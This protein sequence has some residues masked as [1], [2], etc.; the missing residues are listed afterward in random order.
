MKFQ[1][2]SGNIAK[3]RVISPGNYEIYFM[4]LV[5]TVL[6]NEELQGGAKWIA[7]AQWDKY[8]I[9][10][11]VYTKSEAMEIAA[12]MIDTKIENF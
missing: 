9:S 5:C 12:K 8:T 4:D 11:P 6:R 1:L 10:D 7:Y 2:T 3:S